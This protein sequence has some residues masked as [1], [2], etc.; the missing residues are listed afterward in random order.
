MFILFITERGGGGKS[1]S[2]RGVCVCHVYVNF[3]FVNEWGY[4][5]ERKRRLPDLLSGDDLVLGSELEDK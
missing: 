4:R 2:F 1:E 5:N 3:Q